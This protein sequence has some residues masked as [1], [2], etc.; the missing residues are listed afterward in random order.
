MNGKTYRD[1]YAILGIPRTADEKTIKQSYRRLARKYHPDVNPGD[2]SAEE[3]FKEI[4]EAYEVLSDPH[5]RAEYDRF[6]EA[7]KRASQQGS[8]PYSG[9]FNLNFGAGASGFNLNDL[10]NNLFGGFPSATTVRQSVGEDIEYSL[11]ISM[12]EA[13]RGGPV[14][15]SYMVEDICHDCGGTGHSRSARGAFQLGDVCRKCG[16]RGRLPSRRDVTVT[17]P[18]GVAEGMRLRLAGQGSAGTSGTRGDLYLIVQIKPHPNF[19]L[20]GRDI[21]TNVD[22][23]FT[24]AALGGFARVLTL[25]GTTE[26]TI[27]PGI[28][29]GQKLRLAGKGMPAVSGKPAGDL[30]VKV[31]VTVPKDLSPRERQVLREIALARGDRIRQ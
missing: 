30:Y 5:K 24:I 11:E 27:P 3:K 25:D 16:G 22:V 6:G 2:K 7:W 28:R 10:L 15:R 23:P 13:Y 4:S 21:L 12:E 8:Y 18:A 31:Q 1:Y 29:S 20:N 17:I 19:E 9:D 26:V 14:N